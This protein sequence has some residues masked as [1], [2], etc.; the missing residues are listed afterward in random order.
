MTTKWRDAG[1]HRCEA[2][3]VGEGQLRKHSFRVIHPLHVH[4]LYGG[5]HR[6]TE[7]TGKER[8]QQRGHLRGHVGE[9]QREERD[10]GR[11]KHSKESCSVEMQVFF[12]EAGAARV[13]PV[14]VRHRDGGRSSCQRG[15]V[16]GGAPSGGRFPEAS[17]SIAEQRGLLGNRALRTERCI[18]NGACI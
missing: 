5:S 13:N 14:S 12:V 2:R 15:Q 9:V 3:F 7:E 17:P 8:R 11:G 4:L 10:S 1:K 6:G 16:G 18:S